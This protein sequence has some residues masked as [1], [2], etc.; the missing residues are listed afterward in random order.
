MDH[1]YTP[2][3][4]NFPPQNQIRAAAEAGVTGTGKLKQKLSKSSTAADKSSD[5]FIAS[6]L[7]QSA[8]HCADIL[9]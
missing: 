2:C 4:F 1:T 7:L 5:V 3:C 8:R 6:L 9:L